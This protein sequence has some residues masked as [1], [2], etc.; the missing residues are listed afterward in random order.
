MIMN[1][2]LGETSAVA[3]LD[4]YFRV[5]FEK[6]FCPILYYTDFHINYLLI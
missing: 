5:C 4:F 1:D 6:S 2:E 3:F